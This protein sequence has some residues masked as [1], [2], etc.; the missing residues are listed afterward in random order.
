MTQEEII[1]GNELIAKFM[2]YEIPNQ[3]YVKLKWIVYDGVFQSM[4]FHCSWDWLMSV[5]EKIEQEGHLVHIVKQ[6]V[7]IKIK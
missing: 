5:V 4:K 2:E 6:N 7:M 1:E 3:T